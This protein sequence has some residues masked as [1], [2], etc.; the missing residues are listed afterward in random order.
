M[1]KYEVF[2]TQTMTIMTVL[3]ETAHTEICRV[4][5]RHPGRSEDDRDAVCSAEEAE[6][7]ATQLSA[8]LD[9][10]AKEAVRKICRLFKFCSVVKVSK[11]LDP[12]SAFER[13]PAPWNLRLQELKHAAGPSESAQARVSG[14]SVPLSG[15]VQNE[16]VVFALPATAPPQQDSIPESSATQKSD[17]MNTF[18]SALQE[19]GAKNQT[20][21]VL[22]T[23]DTAGASAVKD[24]SLVDPLTDQ[25]ISQVDVP[26]KKALCK[27]DECGKAFVKKSSLIQHK[28][29]HSNATLPPC[30]KCGKKYR[31]PKALERHVLSHS[32]KKKEPRPCKTQMGSLKEHMPL[33]GMVKPFMCEKCGKTF[34]YNYALRNH[35]FTHTDA[36]EEPRAEKNPQR[37]DVCGKCYSSTYA[38]KM[39]QR[40]H[41]ENDPFCCKVCGKSFSSMSGLYAHEQLHSGLKAYR[42]KI[43]Q[44]R[45]MRQNLQADTDPDEGHSFVKH[46]AW[47]SA[48]LAHLSAVLEMQVKDAVEKICRLFSDTS[49]VLHQHLPQRQIACNNLKRKQKPVAKRQTVSRRKQGHHE[50][51]KGHPT[52][53]SE[54]S[55]SA[56]SQSWREVEHQNIDNPELIFTS[57]STVQQT[58][59]M[60]EFM[61]TEKE[62]PE[63]SLDNAFDNGKSGENNEENIYSQPNGLRLHD[64]RHMGQNGFTCVVCGMES[65]CMTA[66]DNHLRTHLGETVS[67]SICG[68]RISSLNSLQNHQN[69]HG[70]NKSH[71]CGICKKSFR[72]A[73]NLKIHERTHTGERPYSCSVCGRTFTQQNS[74]KSHLL[75]HTGE[76]PFSCDVCG[77]GFS[78]AGNLRRHQRVHTGQKPYSCNVCERSFTQLNTLKAHMYIHTGE[79]QYTCDK[80]GRSFGYQRNLKSHKC[81]YD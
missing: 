81:A 72:S 9:F 32:E 25:T 61:D 50:I 65:G 73:G 23:A 1:S 33:H 31:F 51:P 79:K 66:L 19:A 14:V 17:S 53:A 59:R 29:R 28:Q 56:F 38:L 8:V 41:S 69:Q 42:R 60:G 27:C 47:S 62:G 35:M 76:R 4:F 24:K 49:A 10:L 45:D 22:I 11:G 26:K 40:L 44:M 58:T 77:K 6:L 16:L 12:D 70:G 67:C 30:E 80:C 55:V 57:V 7:K 48:L 3:T 52:A 64:G 63:Q 43:S 39:H 36:G 46:T 74:L 68:E 78:S 5:G 71:R 13:V 75:S 20:Q 18:V 21:T 15:K 2:Q 34:V 37:C 54:E